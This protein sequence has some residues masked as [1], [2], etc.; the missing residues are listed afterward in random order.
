MKRVMVRYKTKPDRARENEQLIES[1]FQ[2]LQLSRP[3]GFRYASFKLGDGVS[4][5]HI[6]CIE[7]AD[8]SNPLTQSAAFKSFQAGIKDRCEEQPVATDVSEIGSYRLFGWP[9]G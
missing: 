3:E 9:T 1:V 5:V 2:E 4:F 6:S 7:T 8:G